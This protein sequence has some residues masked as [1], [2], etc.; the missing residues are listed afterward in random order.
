[1]KRFN[2]II[3]QY[4][5]VFGYLGEPSEEE[6]QESLDEKK[7]LLKQQLTELIG[8]DKRKV[9]YGFVLFFLSIAV[10]LVAFWFKADLGNIANIATLTGIAPFPIYIVVAN[11]KKEISYA[12]SLLQMIDKMDDK[13]FKSLLS[14][15][16]S[17]VI[18]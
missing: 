3:R 4:S 5:P 15:F 1:M 13:Y 10:T 6:Q 11:L 8:I 14:L 18:K 12:E 9:N 17:I 7:C 2:N 16:A